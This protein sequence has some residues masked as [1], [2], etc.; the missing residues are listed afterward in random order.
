MRDVKMFL[1]YK[2]RQCS[3][4]LIF[5]NKIKFSTLNI[6][7]LYINFQVYYVKLLILFFKLSESKRVLKIVSTLYEAFKKLVCKKTFLNINC[8]I[9]INVLYTQRIFYYV[10]YHSEKR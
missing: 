8:D 10:L 7:N 1:K 9:N 4:W 2:K 3:I 5:C 6:A